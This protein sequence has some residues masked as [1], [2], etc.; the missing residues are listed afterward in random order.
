M[1]IDLGQRRIGL[2][3]SDPTATL[4]RPLRTIERT[5]SDEQAAEAL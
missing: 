2:A 5:V 1:G 3:I 4:A